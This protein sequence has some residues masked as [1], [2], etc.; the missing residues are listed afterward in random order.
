MTMSQLYTL[1][2]TKLYLLKSILKT[3]TPN[4]IKVTMLGI[5]LI[6]TNHAKE[7]EDYQ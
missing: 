7:V 3:P 2:G 1:W 6:T 4:E 5:Q